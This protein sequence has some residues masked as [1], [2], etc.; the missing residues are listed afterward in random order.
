MTSKLPL[1]NFASARTSAANCYVQDRVLSAW[2]LR[3]R[4]EGRQPPEG[5]QRP[6]QQCRMQRTQDAELGRG[7][8]VHC[9]ADRGREC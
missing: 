7:Y 3:V 4:M 6:L 9:T 2:R 8:E 1:C 5:A